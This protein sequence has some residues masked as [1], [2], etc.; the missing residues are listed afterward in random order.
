MVTTP[1][2]CD[3]PRRDR[4]VSSDDGTLKVLVQGPYMIS[5]LSVTFASQGKGGVA[6][7]G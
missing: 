4:G 1:L 6:S 2:G 5:D 3:D 7:S